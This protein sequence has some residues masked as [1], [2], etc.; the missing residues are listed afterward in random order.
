MA[1][2]LRGQLFSGKGQSGSPSA[3][4]PLVASPQTVGNELETGVARHVRDASDVHRRQIHAL[5]GFVHH[6]E[7]NAGKFSAGFEDLAV[8]KL[9]GGT[10][11][12]GVGCNLGHLER[13]SNRVETALLICTYGRRVDKKSFYLIRRN[14][15]DHIRSYILISRSSQ[16]GSYASLTFA[17]IP[18]CPRAADTCERLTR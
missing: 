15:S 12:R 8:R 5:S 4:R 10:A 13:C 14:Y 2:A 9:Y 1:L 18:C 16:M 6:S 7:A 17:D 11:C 3:L